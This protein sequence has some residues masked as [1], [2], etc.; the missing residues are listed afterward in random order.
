MGALTPSPASSGAPTT[1]TWGTLTTW[2]TL[3]NSWRCFATVSTRA[4]N[5]CRATRCA[6]ALGKPPIAQ[7]LCAQTFVDYPMLRLHMR[8]KKHMHI[9][10]NSQQY[11]RF[12]LAN[13]VH[14]TPSALA[15]QSE[16]EEDDEDAVARSEAEWTDWDSDAE[17]SAS[18]ALCLFC[19]ALFPTS[20]RCIE[21]LR[22]VHS[23]DLVA[24]IDEFKV[25]F[26]SRFPHSDCLVWAV[27]FL[28]SNQ[29]DQLRAPCSG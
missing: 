16:E 2:C 28:C 14:F 5:A 8:K 3:T 11:D 9:P 13:Y 27:G 6:P 19:P 4:F 18:G 12:Y 7:P 25:D 1:F 10:P 22:L 26:C 24:I 21:H 20:Q 17:G 23:F 15:A 29:V